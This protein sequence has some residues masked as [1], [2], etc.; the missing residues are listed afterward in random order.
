MSAADK[1][2]F[3]NYPFLN[4]GGEMATFIQSNDWSGTHLG[5]IKEW[6]Q[7]LKTTLGIVLNSKLPTMLTWGSEPIIFHNDALALS[8]NSTTKSPLPL[9]L[10]TVGSSEGVWNFIRPIVEK[11]MGNGTASHVENQQIPTLRK[12]RMEYEYWTFSFSP[13]SDEFGQISGVFIS[14]DETT[15]KVSQRKKIL[16]NERNLRLIILQAPV[17]IAIFRGPDYIVEIV[18]SRALDL[19]GKKSADIFNKPV[20][21]S[22]RELESQGMKA[23][24]DQVYKSGD[25]YVATELAID[26]FRKSQMETVYVNFVYEPLYDLEGNINGIIAIGTEVTEQVLTRQHIEESAKKLQQ[27]NQEI[28]V[29]NQELAV[30]NDRLE[31][32]EEMLRFSVEAAEAATWYM[33]LDT[34]R[35]LASN[36]LKELFG[37]SPDLAI[38]YKEIFNR[39]PEEYVNLVKHAFKETI[40]HGTNYHMEHPIV[41]FDGKKRWLRALGKL[42]NDKATQKAHFSGLIIDITEDK[43]NELRKN[44][45]IGMVSHELKTPLTSIMGYIQLLTAKAEIGNDAFGHGI[46]QKTNIQVKKMSS[47]INGF[48]NI[49]RLES[50]KISIDKQ[51]FDIYE[52][53]MEITEELRFTLTKHKINLSLCERISVYGDREKIGSVVSNLIGNAIKYSPEGGNIEIHCS[54]INGVIQV[55]IKDDGIGINANDLEKLFDRF[56]R[57][58]NINTKHIA[59]FGIG[60]YLSAEIIQRHDGRIWAESEPGNGSTFYF[61]L[62]ATVPS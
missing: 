8:F 9:S 58:E 29:S 24:L 37:L 16:E 33:E 17:A 48:L 40:N 59:G 45:F 46:L 13:V 28:L 19:W 56:Y 60:L 7:S 53:I 3:Q 31:R 54:L 43:E 26:L 47:M 62:P 55:S 39:I 15:K 61:S 35:F 27:I 14:C 32:A 21:T 1:F 18:N 57:V 6:P 44:D 38:D 11:V 30:S 42:Y 23:I 51:L 25:P 49:S 5:P 2:P 12:D 41:G 34:K 22:M 50:G 52:L 20:F 36:R 4:G 10:K